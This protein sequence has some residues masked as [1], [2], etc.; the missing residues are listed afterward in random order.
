[1]TDFSPSPDTGGSTEEAGGEIPPAPHAAAELPSD[2]VEPLRARAGLIRAKGTVRIATPEGELWVVAPHMAL[3]G[4]SPFANAGPLLKPPILRAAYSDRTAWLMAELSRLAYRKFEADEAERGDLVAALADAG[5]ELVGPF[6]ARDTGTQGFV[7]VAP[8]RFAVLVFRGTEKDFKDIRAD[9][10]ARFMKSASGRAHRGFVTAYDSA[11]DQIRSLLDKVST[12]LPLYVAGHS[13]GGALATV[14]GSDLARQRVVAACY[15]FGSPRVGDAE[16]SDGV[17]IPVYR[18]VNGADGVPMVPLSG[19]AR[20]LLDHVP[21]VPGLG[22]LKRPFAALKKKGYVGYQHVG[23]LR[24]LAGD[25]DLPVLK[26][27]SAALFARW[28]TVAVSFVGGALRLSLARFSGYF[29]DHAV[30]EYTA[31]LR[32][33]AEKRNADGMIG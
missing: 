8:G 30:A 24:F 12:D 6:D 15:T 5:L 26:T 32:T 16:W 14:A 11:A 28:R 3:S 9:L 17:K 4:R 27:G 21:E 18:V 29:R 20:W 22:M 13:L 25:A 2:V 19:F 1:M 7:A 10:D 23:D 31:R 33:L